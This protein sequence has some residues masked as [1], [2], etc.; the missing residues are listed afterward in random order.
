MKGNIIYQTNIRI[1]KKTAFKKCIKSFCSKEEL[2]ALFLL[3]NN[4]K[5]MTNV[6][7]TIWIDFLLYFEK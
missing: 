7:K 1:I 5:Q 4:L 6:P 3:F 2:Y